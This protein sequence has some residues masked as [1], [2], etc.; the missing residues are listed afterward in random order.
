MN[1]RLSLFISILLVL[2]S[3]APANAS[4]RLGSACK[5]LN[6]TKTI[7]GQKLI[8]LKKGSKKIWSKDVRSASVRDSAPAKTPTS[9]SAS[10]APQ[11]VV[12]PDPKITARSLLAPV[13]ECRLPFVGENSDLYT[14]F[15]RNQKYIPA[16]GDR[17]SVVL[18]VDFPDLPSDSKA[19]AE[20]KNT[21]VP[22]AEKAWRSMSYEK[23]RL[24]FDLIEKFFRIP[25]KW[26][27]FVKNEAGN[28]AGS[29]PALAMNHQKLIVETLNVADA[30]VDFSKYDFINIVTPGTTPKVEPGASGGGG[31]NADGKTNFL[32][33]SGPFDEYQG[34]PLK[35]SWLAHEA[36]HLLG[37][38]HIY[39]FRQRQ[40]AWDLMGN[41]FANND[42]FG[43]SKFF[44]AWI[45][46]NQV[47]C[48]PKNLAQETT[49]LITPLGEKDD[50]TKLVMIP[51]SQ[52]Q[53][54]VIESRRSTALDPIDKNA[55]GVLVYMVDTSISDG[56]GTI[57]ILSNPNK[58][59]RDK[60]GNG[61]I[62]GTMQAN[63]SVQASGY[64]IKYLKRGLTG[65]FVSVAK[66]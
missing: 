13:S 6:Q 62:L 49:H 22:F 2:G 54:I 48:L 37:L 33:I 55:E 56:K 25:S 32:A 35:A 61:V 26:Q 14:G 11:E 21:Q 52:T 8:C 42:I 23:Y 53:A 18:F 36:G 57:S 46:E 34:D 45:N 1:R 40:G 31:F 17:K 64:V 44:L 39:D 28:I 16:E 63:E 9:S 47:N 59:A 60:R 65:D 38:T 10:P 5:S 20:W 50:G 30:E 12:I 24:K 4:V 3:L 51:I 58:V 43:W 19:I 27:D 15:P 41:V 66:S 29:T 7:N